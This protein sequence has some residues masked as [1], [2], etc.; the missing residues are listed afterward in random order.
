MSCTTTELGAIR[1]TANFTTWSM[2]HKATL[3]TYASKISPLSDSDK[4]DVS[5]ILDDVLSMKDCLEYQVKSNGNVHNTIYTS[6]Q[7]VTDLNTQIA[8]EEANASIARDRVAYIRHPEQHVSNYESWFPIDRP[9]HTFSLIVLMSMTVF[10]G[11]FL[12]L[13]ILAMCG[14][15]VIFYTDSNRS[16]KSNYSWIRDQ[17]TPFS[18]AT[19]IA[20]VAVVIYFTQRK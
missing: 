4:S 19:L 3:N 10:L 5:R 17:I 14:V 7:S 9:I 6:Q 13:V 2:N 20:L 15:N 11:T 16:Y 8:Q 18:V 1:N 12:I